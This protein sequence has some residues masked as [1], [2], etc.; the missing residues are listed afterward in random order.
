MG[1]GVNIWWRN[2]RL[3]LGSE[4]RG[5]VNEMGLRV[6]GSW[7]ISGAAV[8]LHPHELFVTSGLMF[9][10]ALNCFNRIERSV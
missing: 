8:C 6:G 2:R 4:L 7:Q 3:S 9:V 10:R 1:G 5:K